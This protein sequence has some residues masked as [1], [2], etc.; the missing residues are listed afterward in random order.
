MAKGNKGDKGQRKDKEKTKKLPCTCSHEHQ[1][2]IY[3]KGIRLMNLRAGDAG[4]RC[5]V[6]SKVK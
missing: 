3:G 5:T 6:C 1:D 2:L 4:Y